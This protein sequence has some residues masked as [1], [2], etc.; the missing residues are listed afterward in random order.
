MPSDRSARIPACHLET[1][2]SAYLL[3]CSSRGFTRNVLRI[4]LV[5]RRHCQASTVPSPPLSSCADVEAGHGT[6]TIQVKESSHLLHGSA[7]S[8]GTRRMRLGAR[9]TSVPQ[10][11]ACVGPSRRIRRSGTSD[12]SPGGHL[13]IPSSNASMNSRVYYRDVRRPNRN[14]SGS[15][16]TYRRFT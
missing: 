14:E 2:R 6:F 8:T 12:T 9:Q 5:Q 10:V 13:S 15:S 4:A 3:P 1:E 7:P 16:A 11:G